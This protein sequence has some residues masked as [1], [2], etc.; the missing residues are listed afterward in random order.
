MDAASSPDGAAFS[1]PAG[2][3]MPVER[4]VDVILRFAKCELDLDRLVLRRDGN[5]GFVR[6]WERSAGS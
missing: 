3:G 2:A 6:F 1:S 5:D 4:R